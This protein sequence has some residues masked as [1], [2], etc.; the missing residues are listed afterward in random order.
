VICNWEDYCTICLQAK[1]HLQELKKIS[2][3]DNKF[4]ALRD[5]TKR[6]DIKETSSSTNHV[7]IFNRHTQPCIPYLGPMLNELSVLSEVSQ[8]FLGAEDGTKHINFKKL[9]QVCIKYNMLTP[10][11]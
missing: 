2:S 11:L 4:K 9:H 6:S 3:T 7:L 8:T 1:Y 5:A 10:V